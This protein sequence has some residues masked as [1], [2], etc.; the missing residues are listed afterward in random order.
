MRVVGRKIDAQAMDVV[1]A[2]ALRAQRPIVVSDWEG[3]WV[4]ADHAYDVAKKGIPDGDKLFR[5][6]GNY[7]VHLSD[8]RKL[9]RFQPGETLALIAP[10]LISYG[11]SEKLLYDIAKEDA[12]FIDGALEGIKVIRESGSSFSVVSTSYH[13]YVWYTAP[14]AG[15]PEEQTRSTYFPIEDFRRHIRKDDIS[16][17]KEMTPKIVETVN[18]GIDSIRSERDTSPITREAIA[19]MDRFFLSVLPGTSFSPVLE[20]VRPIG[21]MRKLDALQDILRLEERRIDEAVVIGDSITDRNMLGETKKA[22]GLAIS[23]N[24]NKHSIDAANVAVASVDCMITPALI[25]IFGRS[26]ISEIEQLATSWSTEML[27]REVAFGN[28]D[29]QLFERI[30]KI[31]ELETTKVI[32]LTEETRINALEQSAKTRALV[33]GEDGKLK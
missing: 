22:G 17:V 12:R 10:F 25:Q 8:A 29:Q 31:A 7:V 9:E 18:L 33:R 24:G 4:S 2:S 3:P 19:M 30:S 11:V 6:L 13:Q 5:A 16:Q 28:L 23:F 27:R 15:V 20:N 21:G 1:G 26:G 32:W 14:L